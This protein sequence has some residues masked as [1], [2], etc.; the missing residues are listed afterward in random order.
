MSYTTRWAYLRWALHRPHGDELLFVGSGGIFE[1][2]TRESASRAIHRE[3]IALIRNRPM[4]RRLTTAGGRGGLH[5]A[6]QV[7]KRL[8]GRSDRDLYDLMKWT[9]FSH[10]LEL[11]NERVRLRDLRK[12]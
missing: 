2:A 4:V 5:K 3:L 9:V 6:K 7:T 12:H 8:L 11:Q 1:Y 10:E